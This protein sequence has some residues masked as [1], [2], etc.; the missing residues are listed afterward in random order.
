ME[1]ANLN[2]QEAYVVV[3]PGG[4]TVFV[5]NGSGA[6]QDEKDYAQKV[7]ALLIPGAAIVTLEEEAESDDFWSVLGGKTEYAKTKGL[8]F[9]ANFSARLFQLSNSSGYFTMNEIYNFCQGDLNVHDVMVLDVFSTFYIWV[10]TR[11]NET[12]RK[13]GIKKVENYIQ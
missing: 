10:G 6:N 2:S 13:N 3:K 7:A 5:W 11:A 4:E 1:C 8:N 9:P 12:E